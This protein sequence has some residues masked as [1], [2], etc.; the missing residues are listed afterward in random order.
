MHMT[1]LQHD[2]LSDMSVGEEMKKDAA[3]LKEVLK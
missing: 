3:G 2:M 1:R